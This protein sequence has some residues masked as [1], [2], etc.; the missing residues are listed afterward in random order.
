MKMYAIWEGQETNDS[1]PTLVGVAK[2][3][4]TAKRVCKEHNE[5]VCSTCHQKINRGED[6]KFWYE[7]VDLFV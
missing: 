2:F 4:E 5:L 7:E 6:D 1:Y 3:V